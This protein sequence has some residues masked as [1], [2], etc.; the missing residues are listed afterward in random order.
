MGYHGI[1]I[2]R[3][4]VNFSS[5]V[6]TALALHQ[7]PRQRV[8]PASRRDLHLNRCM[9]HASRV[10]LLSCVYLA[11]QARPAGGCGWSVTAQ[12]CKR[13]RWFN[14]ICCSCD[15]IKWHYESTVLVMPVMFLSF[16]KGKNRKQRNTQVNAA[17]ATFLFS[18]C[19]SADIC[20][21]RITTRSP[22][23][24]SPRRVTGN[25]TRLPPACRHTLQSDTNIRRTQ[26]LVCSRS[27]GTFYLIGLCL[28]LLTMLVTAPSGS[29]G[30]T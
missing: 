11:P 6:H 1:R 15:S 29:R 19:P 18:N 5:F 13:W 23:R 9:R 22:S 28:H 16:H 25:V 30:V 26:S 12:Y 21:S 8:H 2:K 3:T 27:L 20:I 10:V 24:L 7:Y 17:V 14:R 4:L